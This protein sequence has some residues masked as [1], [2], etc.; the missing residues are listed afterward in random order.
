VKPK[1]FPDHFNLLLTNDE[2]MALGDLY[3]LDPVPV[4]EIDLLH[5]ALRAG[6]KAMNREGERLRK[7][8][9]RGPTRTEIEA[10]KRSEASGPTVEN[11]V[12]TPLEDRLRKKLE[13]FLRDHPNAMSE[14]EALALLMDLGLRGF[15]YLPRE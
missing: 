13:A 11:Y 10:R 14:E 2:R 9:D 1:L 6:I 5:K 4:D 8:P 7:H 3:N 12:C 15:E